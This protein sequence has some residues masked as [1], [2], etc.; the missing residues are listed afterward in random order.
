[1]SKPWCPIHAGYAEF[2]SIIYDVTIWVAPD[3]FPSVEDAE[4]FILQEKMARPQFISFLVQ[5]V[6]Q[7]VQAKVCRTYASCYTPRM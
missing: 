5:Y 2:N 4:K 1:M 3:N 7:L 6:L